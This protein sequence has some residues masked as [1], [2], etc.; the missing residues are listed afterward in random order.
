MFGK[1]ITDAE[2]TITRLTAVIAAIGLAADIT[3]EA[4]AASVEEGKKDATAEAATPLN[5]RIAALETQT[6]TMRDGME[7]AGV[8]LGAEVDALTV[9]GVKAAIEARGSAMAAKIVAAAGHEP[10][11]IPAGNDTA[12]A[13]AEQMTQVELADAIDKEKD[14]RKRK[15]LFNVFKR[16]FL[17]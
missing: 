7:A 12:S 11:A 2:A 10:L 3:P 14:H 9:D 6:K 8:K 5:Q 1:K 16:R 15:D 17:D 4:A 13:G